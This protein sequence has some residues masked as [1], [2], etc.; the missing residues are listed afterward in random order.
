MGTYMVQELHNSQW[1]NQRAWVWPLRIPPSNLIIK[2]TQ[3]AD[4]LCSHFRTVSRGY[5]P[6]TL[7]WDQKQVIQM[8]GSE[9]EAVEYMKVQCQLVPRFGRQCAPSDRYID[10]N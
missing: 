4:M 6:F 7:D 8:A 2:N 5:L 10:T 9:K 1:A 3:I